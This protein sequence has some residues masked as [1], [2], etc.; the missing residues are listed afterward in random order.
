[1]IRVNGV[2]Y[3]V[4]LSTFTLHDPQEVVFGLTDF[5][6]CSIDI[7]SGLSRDKTEQV[8]FHELTHILV[9]REEI[10]DNEGFVSRVSELLYG[11]LKDNGMLSDGWFDRIVDK[12]EQ[13]QV[14]SKRAL[15]DHDPPSVQS[16]ESLRRR[17]YAEALPAS[18]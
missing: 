11:V 16:N 2:S 9:N 6:E 7:H 3:P 12:Q 13:E 15:V 18:R 14:D 10:I 4:R 1:M 17:D 8:L 5:T